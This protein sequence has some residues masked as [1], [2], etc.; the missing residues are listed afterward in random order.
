VGAL[1]PIHLVVILVI[2]L[3]VFGAGR[4]PEVGG[5]LG[6]GIRDFRASAADKPTGGPAPAGSGF[7]PSCGARVSKSDAR[8]CEECGAAV[9]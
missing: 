7:C 1:Q 9:R 2:V 3:V 8:F 5:A 6:K 4:L